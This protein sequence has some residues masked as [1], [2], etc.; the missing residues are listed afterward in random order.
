MGLL[1]P[2]KGEIYIDKKLLFSSTHNKFLYNLRSL[3]SHVPQ[4]IYLINASIVENIAFNESQRDINLE[5]V[6]Q[7]LK[8]VSLDDFVSNLPKGLQTVIG[9]NGI[10]LSGGQAQR[11]GIARALYRKKPILILD[12]A[13]SALDEV[14]ED[15]ILNSI[16]KKYKKLSIIMVTHKIKNLRFFDRLISIKK[17]KIYNKLLNKND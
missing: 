2:T 16:F 11:I 6:N 15:K 10:K 12:E 4:N 17:G 9:E 14:T 8:V 7:L 3:V 5:L 1:K 13:T